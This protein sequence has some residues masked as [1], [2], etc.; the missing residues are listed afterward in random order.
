MNANKS[1]LVHASR[2]ADK[3]QSQPKEAEPAGDSKEHSQE[4]FT[5][6]PQSG[7]RTAKKAA[8]GIPEAQR[9]HNKRKLGFSIV[10]FGRVSPKM[11]ALEKSPFPGD[12]AFALPLAH[13]ERFNLPEVN[14]EVS[15]AHRNT[16]ASPRM[17]KYSDRMPLWKVDLTVPDAG[18]YSQ[19][20]QQSYEIDM[21]LAVGSLSFS[22]RPERF[23]TSCEEDL[24]IY[25]PEKVINGK[26]VCQ[27]SRV[28]CFVNIDQQ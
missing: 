18:N 11:F 3:R 19:M 24:R 5:S 26:E 8:T 25:E 12:A 22:K 28:P 16:K 15:G 4:P 6:T 13:D 9:Y 21:G 7:H 23:K 2:F 27:K 14:M 20:A 10:E 17:D 1:L